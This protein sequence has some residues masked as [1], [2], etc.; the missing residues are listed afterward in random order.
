MQSASAHTEPGKLPAPLPSRARDG[1]TN[2]TRVMT[3]SQLSK[4]HRLMVDYMVH[5]LHHATLLTRLPARYMPAGVDE[6]GAPIQKLGRPGVH[7]ALTLED[8]AAA[9]NIRPRIARLLSK[10]PVF[11]RLLAQETAAFRN[12]A[13]ARATR[14]M[15]ALIDE[16]GAGKA[17]D[18]KVQLAAAQAVLGESDGNRSGVTI[19]MPGSTQIV[20]GV[21]IRLPHTAQ[22]TPLEHTHQPSIEHEDGEPSR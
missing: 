1:L 7:E 10:Q 13:K 9:C 5:G 22:R 12:G 2:A 14:R 4:K 15:V 6:D 20:A 8:A 11:Q 3:E 18:R 16:P 19:N 21:V 17:A